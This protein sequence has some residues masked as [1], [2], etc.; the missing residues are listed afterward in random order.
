MEE[1]YMNEPME[2]NLILIVLEK[3]PRTLKKLHLR[4]YAWDREI[5]YA[6]H[7]LFKHL[8]EFEVRFGKG[9]LEEVRILGCLVLMPSRLM[10]Y[11]IYPF[12]RTHS[13]CWAPTSSR[14]S[15]SCILSGSST[16][17]TASSG[18]SSSAHITPHLLTHTTTTC[19][20]M[21]ALI[22]GT[23]DRQ[24]VEVTAVEVLV[25]KAGLVAAPDMAHSLPTTLPLLAPRTVSHRLHLHRLFPAPLISLT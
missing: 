23:G 18:S 20:S 24:E 7:S 14:T 13:W 8:T 10:T 15:S 6:A 17:P 11:H 1:V 19:S 3:L 22:G 2:M 25:D 16:H 12:P 9:S 5:L 4:M 21:V